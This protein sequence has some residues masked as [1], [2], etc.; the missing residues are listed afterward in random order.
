M[1]THCIKKHCNHEFSS[2]LFQYLKAAATNFT[3]PVFIFLPLLHINQN[4]NTGKF[5]FRILVQFVN[6]YNL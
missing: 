4:S 2:L 1:E 5:Q 3:K 6:M